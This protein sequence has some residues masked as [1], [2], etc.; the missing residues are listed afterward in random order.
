MPKAIIKGHHRLD[1]TS[2][3]KVKLE[4]GRKQTEVCSVV[5]VISVAFLNVIW[6]YI[7]EP[8]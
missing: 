7:C 2:F 1:W 6:V 5:A 8:I 4:T 3:I